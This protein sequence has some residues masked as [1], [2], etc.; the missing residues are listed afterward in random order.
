MVIQ[1]P[2]KTLNTQ[3]MTEAYVEEGILVNS[4]RFDGM[5]NMKAL[6]AIAAYL[7]SLGRGKKT[8]QYRLRDWG[9][10][11]QRY[12]GAPIPVINCEKC[13]TVP[14]PE[15]DLPVVL[16]RDVAFT[17]EGGSP[18]ARHGPL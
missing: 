8:I 13:G 6:D 7:E 1:P 10:S 17:G 3:T 4:G 9:I 18:L 5:E 12:W 11:R 2:D 16:P 14:V 15:K